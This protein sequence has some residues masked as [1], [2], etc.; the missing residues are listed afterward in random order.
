MSDRAVDERACAPGTW[1]LVVDPRG[2]CSAVSRSATVRD[3][4]VAAETRA[5]SLVHGRYYGL[6]DAGPGGQAAGLLAAH[7]REGLGMLR[8]IGGFFSFAIW[9]RPSET[10]ICGRDPLGIHPLFWTRTGAGLML[11]PSLDTLV[12]QPEVP[13]RV[14]RAAIAD[15]LRHHWPRPEETVFDGISRVLPGHWLR[16]RGGSVTTE[17]YWDPLF[18]GS[19]PEWIDHADLAR[20]DELLDRSVQ[21]AV[22]G[23]RTAIYLSGGLDSVS[24]GALASDRVSR[25]GTSA[26]LALSLA[27]PGPENEEEIQRGVADRLGMPHLVATLSGALGGDRLVHAAVHRGSVGAP[28]QNPWL[29]AYRWL[30]G[31]AA[32]RGCD[33]VLTGS[34]GDEWLTVTPLYS[35]DLIRTGRLGGL[36]R[37][38]RTQARSYDLSPLPL[39]RSLLWDYGLR[40][41]A[42]HRRASLM[43]RFTPERYAARRYESLQSLL[44]RRPWLVRDPDLRAQ[45]RSRDADW[46]R[47][48]S[49]DHLLPLSGPREYFRECRKALEHPLVSMEAEEVFEYSAGVGVQVTHPYWDTR[50]VEFLHA[51]PPELLNHDGRAK[52]LIRNTLSRRFPHLGFERQRKVVTASFFG[53]T[54]V[55]EAPTVWREIGGIQALADAGIVDPEVGGALY[56]ERPVTPHPATTLT[57]PMWELLTVEGWLRRHI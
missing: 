16:V 8:G 49:A 21:R 56:L 41:L 36:L 17:R 3:L 31:Q 26:P 13:R 32:G 42:V 34:G 6:D 51:T 2:G 25:D 57:D 30:A 23:R 7:R 55:R 29:P 5:L 39:A 24:V 12:R 35:A 54:V 40:P 44:A 20:F 14:N 50:L 22:D 1:V 53:K 27:F 4:D 52:A 38:G 47:G 11:S 9:D 46:A 15:H 28:L 33:T 18:P 10:L 45:L 37:L 48:P 43:R 19:H